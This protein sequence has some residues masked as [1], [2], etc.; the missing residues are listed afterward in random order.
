MWSGTR[1]Y[2]TRHA[3]MKRF[4]MWIMSWQRNP[5]N[6]RRRCSEREEHCGAHEPNRAWCHACIASGGRADPHAMR[7]ES[8]K[9]LL[10]VAVGYGYLRSQSA[11]NAGEVVEEEDDDG[12]PL[13]GIRGW[14][15]F[16]RAPKQEPQ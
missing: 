6:D 15:D 3:E 14:V 13:D 12:N 11:E 4:L 5:R 1:W 16:L 2:E 9:G 10:V 7:N 8:E